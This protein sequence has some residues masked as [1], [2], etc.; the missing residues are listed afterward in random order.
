M[1]MLPKGISQILKRMEQSTTKHLMCNDCYSASASRTPWR[2]KPSNEEKK[3][4]P[5]REEMKPG[6][7]VSVDQVESATPGFMGQITGRLTRLR[8]W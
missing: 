5:K 1:K 4:L 8:I 7:V 2:Q 6:D 3:R